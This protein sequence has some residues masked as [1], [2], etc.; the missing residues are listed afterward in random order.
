MA[1]E[2]DA[3]VVGAGPAGSAAALALARRGFRVVLT[4][5]HTFPRDK[6][7]GDALIPD[8]LQA[9]A[10]L[11][12]RDQLR[13]LAH[14]VD[15]VR[16]YA[17]NLRYATLHGQCACLPR[18]AFDDFLRQAAVAAGASFV[19]PA[20]ALHPVEADGAVRGAGFEDPGTHRRFEV[21]APA[22]ILATGGAAESLDA[23]GMCLRTRPS[24]IAARAYIRVDRDTARQHDY[25]CIAYASE[26]CP[27]YGWFFPGPNRTFNI[28]VG[29]VYE[30]TP[31]ERNVR[32]LLER[33]VATFPPAAALMKAAEHIDPLKGAPLRTA[34]T[35]ARLARP[36]LLVAGEA[37]GL[38]YS[39][40][41]E[42]IGKAM[43]SGIL[44]AETISEGDC[45]SEH[46]ARAIAEK[47]SER[48]TASFGER[49]RAYH[50]LERLVSYAPIANL[51]IWRASAGRYAHDA[52]EDLLNERG[53]PGGGLLSLGGLMRALLT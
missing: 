3:L 48:L 26:I 1:L 50:R 49:F 30:K 52:L 28:G 15:T 6:V 32:K 4:D 43:Q 23:F 12:L 25:L 17:P 27:G 20:R 46:G 11:G 44:A 21:H 9:I 5:R 34:M 53:R 51:L 8:A 14:H 24:A 10:D 47:Y 36:G 29:Y 35:G 22:T 7:C 2:C 45:R 40:S 41:G 38:T 16:I 42:G 33:F 13:P 19:A 18:A 37:A 31:P 39:F